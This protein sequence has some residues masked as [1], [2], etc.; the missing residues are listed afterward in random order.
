[1]LSNNGLFQCSVYRACYY[2]LLHMQINERDNIENLAAL[3]MA[4]RKSG[5]QVRTMGNK[6]LPLPPKPIFKLK[7]FKG[8]ER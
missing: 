4:Y 8:K 1:M 2:Y 5:Y 6:N 3:Y 7:T